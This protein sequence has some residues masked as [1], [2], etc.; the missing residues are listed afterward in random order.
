MVRK[1]ANNTVIKD[2]PVTKIFIILKNK[3]VTREK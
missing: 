1:K 3:F 2:L